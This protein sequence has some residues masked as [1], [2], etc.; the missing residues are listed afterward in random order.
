[1]APQGLRRPLGEEE[2][3]SNSLRLRRFGLREIRIVEI[4]RSGCA[5][6]WSS[7]PSKSRSR[8][9]IVAVLN[10]CGLYAQCPARPCAVSGRLKITR[11]GVIAPQGTRPP[12][13]A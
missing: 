2:T 12:G 9:S 3:Q 11:A 7:T 1:P 5:T 13:V 8:R 4:G 6:I 10:R